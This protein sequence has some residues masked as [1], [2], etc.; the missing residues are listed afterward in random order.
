MI[1]CNGSLLHKICLA[2]PFCFFCSVSFY[3]YFLYPSYL[4]R[5]GNLIKFCS[6]SEI[7]VRFEVCFMVICRKA[8]VLYNY[9]VLVELSIV[10]DIH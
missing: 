7:V 2:I 5:G 10:S 6:F 3:F 4:G 1:S 9:V 8:C